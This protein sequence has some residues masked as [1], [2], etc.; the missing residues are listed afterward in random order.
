MMIRITDAIAEVLASP[1]TSYW[2]REALRAALER[3]AWDAAQ[4]AERLAELLAEHHR[5]R[6]DEMG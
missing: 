6:T 4:D 3:D 5:Q 1:D 2:L